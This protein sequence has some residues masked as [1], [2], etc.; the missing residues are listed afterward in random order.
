MASLMAKEKLS[1]FFLSFPDLDFKLP[2][3]PI[4]LSSPSLSK[5]VFLQVSLQT[6]CN[7][8]YLQSPGMLV[9]NGDSHLIVLVGHRNLHF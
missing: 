7:L 2:F 1:Y 3:V 6:T 9:K 4:D 5:S 8:E